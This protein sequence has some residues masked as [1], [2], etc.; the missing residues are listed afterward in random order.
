M[1][2]T[3]SAHKDTTKITIEQLRTI[4]TPES[5]QYWRPVAHI[6][7]VETLKSELDRRDLSVV[8]EEFAVGSEG[9]K[10][11]GT[12]DINTDLVSGVGLSLGF[13]HSNDK[14]ISIQIVG[15]GRVFVCDNMMLSGDVTLL[16]QKHNWSYNLRSLIQRG[17]DVWQNKRVN[18]ADSIDRMRNT[19][20]ADETAR[21][22]LSKA[23]YEG[24]TTFATFKE[25]YELY[26]ERAVRTPELYQ[27]CAPRSVYGLHNAYTR[28]LK[29]STPNAAFSTNIEL[30]KLFKI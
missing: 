28:A 11:F 17:L 30:G 1:S 6:E 21:A 18:M 29:A 14:R 15:G 16:K 2:S 7:L 13:R 12:L 8:R 19:P 3:L 22:L 4:N 26:F 9:R 25:T 24:V 10:L 5:S 20:I 23:L 27:D